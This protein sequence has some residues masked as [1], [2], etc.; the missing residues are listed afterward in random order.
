MTT[1][2]DY[3]SIMELRKAYTPT[4]RGIITDDEEKLIRETL[5]I[6][7]RN[8]VELQN[9]RDATVMMHSRWAG[10][11]KRASSIPAIVKVLDAMGAICCVIDEEKSKR[12]LP[13]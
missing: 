12:G 2:T 9:I 8:A 10:S 4:Y 13:V 6:G 5:E 3:N 7:S 1:K 11:L